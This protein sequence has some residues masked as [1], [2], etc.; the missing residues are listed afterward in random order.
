LQSRKSVAP[1]RE[2]I[3]P[4]IVGVRAGHMRPLGTT[5]LRRAS[6]TDNSKSGGWPKV[7][8]RLTNDLEQVGGR[9]LLLLR[10]LQLASE[11]RDLYEALRKIAFEERLKIHDLV[12]EGID[13]ALRRRGYPSVEGLK[14]GKKR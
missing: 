13:A 8:G 2:D 3:L 5:A 12:L 9:G 6:A 4:R 11:P 1:R 7:E 14:A 10:L